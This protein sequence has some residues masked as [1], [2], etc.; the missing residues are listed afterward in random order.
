MT[1]IAGHSSCHKVIW[2][3]AAAHETRKKYRDQMSPMGMEE[4]R[5]RMG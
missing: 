4:V 5:T 1:H 3:N 2:N